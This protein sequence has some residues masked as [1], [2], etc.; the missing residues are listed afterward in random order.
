VSQNNSVQ[1]LLTE[2]Q[3]PQFLMEYEGA[4]LLTKFALPVAKSFL[5]KSVEQAMEYSE[6]I[7]YP[8]VLKG[9]SRSIVHKTEAGIVKL[10]IRNS[11]ELKSSYA[12]I[13]SNA[14]RYNSKSVMDGILV[15]KMAPKGIELILGIKKDA[16]FGHQLI[17]GF[18]GTLVEIMKD[19]SMRMMPVTINDVEEMVQELK[20]YPILK[21]YRGQAG[22]NQKQL[23]NI[24]LGLN[25]LVES[26]P[27]IEELDLNPV[28]FAGNDAVICD[29]RILKGTQAKKCEKARTLAYIDKLINPGSIAVVGASQND[30]KS[31]G[32]LLKY[33]TEN[34]YKGDVYPINPSSDRIKGYKAYPSILDVPGEIDLACIMVS[35]K[36]VPSVLEE[37]VQKRIKAAIVYSSGFSEIGEE[38]KKLQEQIVEIAEKGDIR[39]VG[40]NSIGVASPLQNIY[41]A[42]GS[43]LESKEKPP[44]HIGFISQ[45]G[46]MGSA[47]LSRAWEQGAGFSRWISVANEADLTTSDFIEILAEDESTKVISV[48][49]EALKDVD[50]FA[51]ATKKAKEN[52][53]PVLVYKTGRSDVGKRA[54]QSHTGSIAGDDA[55]YSAAFKKFGALRM[56]NLDEVIDVSRAFEVQPLPKGNRIGI[57]TASGGAC[58]VIA[59]LCTERGLIVPELTEASDKISGIIPLFGSS[60]NPVDVTVEVVGKPEMFKQVLEALVQDSQIDGVI[61][62]LTSNADPGA[63][64]IAKA[65]HNVF[66]QNDKPIVLGRLGADAIA[67]NAMSFYREVG[68]PVYP[69]PERVVSVM[70]YLV[71]YRELIIK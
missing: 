5:A 70:D 28:I 14:V 18:G 9:M 65:I 20:S 50:T 3:Q 4:E 51:R 30:K 44:G 13:M 16:V 48:F 35:A 59:D 53:K 39:V 66:T 54:V 55:V 2:E 41:T 40:P 34:D 15:Q 61:I 36:H 6:T 24:C 43:A 27:E 58:S 42:F 25:D 63:T 33:I 1:T 62:M 23:V 57:L 67:P 17:L 38:G 22:I 26:T 37:C 19:F 8:L 32:R 64:I 71:K 56:K 68:F 60:Q 29:V 31:G 21:G 69:T 49:M 47:L 52:K 10:N 46:A 12:E 45:S 7:G 11:E